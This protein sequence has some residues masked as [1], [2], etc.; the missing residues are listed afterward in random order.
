[1]HLASVHVE[2]LY[3]L[4]AC[5]LKAHPQQVT[6]AG[7]QVSSWLSGTAPGSSARGVYQSCNHLPSCQPPSH[8]CTNA[9]IHPAPGL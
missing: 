1:M 4:R 8:P 7:A 9:L 3:V 6:M 2:A 5:S